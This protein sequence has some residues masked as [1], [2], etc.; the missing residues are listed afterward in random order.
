MVNI[1]PRTGSRGVL[2]ESHRILQEIA[3]TGRKS[4]ENLRPE[5]C[6]HKI[7][8]ITRNRPFPGQTV[9]PGY[10]KKYLAVQKNK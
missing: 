8:G 7:S 6:F 9:R 2:Q 10:A 5:Y 4:S 3:G 1:I